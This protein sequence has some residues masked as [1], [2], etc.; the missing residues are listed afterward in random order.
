VNSR[1]TYCGS[2]SYGKG[3]KFGPHGVHLHPDDATKCSFCG[4]K[5]YGRG[6]KINPTS[7]LHVHG[8]AF[9]SMFKEQVQS[10]LDNQVLLTELKRDFKDFGCF[11]LGI[12]D[13]QGNK[14]KDPVSESEKHSFGPFTKTIFKLKKYLGSKLQLLDATNVLKENSIPLKTDL[15]YYNKLLQHQTKVEAVV[16]ELYKV[17]DEAVQ[18]GVSVEDAKKLIGA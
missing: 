12:T 17:I 10:F 15:A 6:C 9:N 13:E 2:I 11:E 3:C 8:I 16:N 14:L 4:S 5:S 7:D 18:D 1:C